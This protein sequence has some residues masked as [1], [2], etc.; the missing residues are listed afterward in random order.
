MPDTSRFCAAKPFKVSE[1]LLIW[2]YDFP[3]M[4]MFY[5]ADCEQRLIMW[6]KKTSVNARIKT[7]L[8]LSQS[9]LKSRE[10]LGFL[11]IGPVIE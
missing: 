5:K 3:K 10:K 4:R 7:I 2:F 11:A 6:Q 8:F 9:N 1:K